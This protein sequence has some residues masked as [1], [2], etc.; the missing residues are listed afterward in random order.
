MKSSLSFR[1]TKLSPL[2]FFGLTEISQ[3]FSPPACNF[4]QEISP[5]SASFPPYLSLLISPPL[6]DQRFLVEMPSHCSRIYE[7]AKN[8]HR[9]R[10]LRFLNLRSRDR[11]LMSAG[12]RSP[13]CRFV[14]NS[15]KCLGSGDLQATHFTAAVRGESAFRIYESQIAAAVKLLIVLKSNFRKMRLELVRIH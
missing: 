1:R 13:F 15:W 10:K 6:S 2:K 14:T 12:I 8:R 9:V 11:Y 7:E 3:Q 5:A 4:F